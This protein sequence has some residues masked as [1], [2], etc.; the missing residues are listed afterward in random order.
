LRFSFSAPGVSRGTRKAS[1]AA[2][3]DQVC[4]FGGTAKAKRSGAG[5]KDGGG[6]ETRRDGEA[7]SRRPQCRRARL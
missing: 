5:P 7:R 4:F 6:A 3:K 1:G 2:P